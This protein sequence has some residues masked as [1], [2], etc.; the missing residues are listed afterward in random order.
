VFAESCTIA[1]CFAFH[2]DTLEFEEEVFVIKEGNLSR[3]RRVGSSNVPFPL[4]PALSL[5][6]RENQGQMVP[7][8]FGAVG[9]EAEF[10]QACIFVLFEI[11]GIVEP[12]MNAIEELG[13]GDGSKAG[14]I[15]VELRFFVSGYGVAGFVEPFG[16]GE[17]EGVGALDLIGDEG[18][19]AVGD[20]GVCPREKAKS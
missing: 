4:T 7:A 12:P 14:V 19:G 3:A 10:F 8:V 16:R 17:V 15:V 9:I 20:L 18:K 13:N 11:F 1:V 5:G 2:G 6:E